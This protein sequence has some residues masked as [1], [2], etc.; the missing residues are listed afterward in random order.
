MRGHK[1]HLSNR[2]PCFIFEAQHQKKQRWQTR[3]RE[4]LEEKLQ[5][6][7]ALT[8]TREEEELEFTRKE[9]Q[10]SSISWRQQLELRRNR[11]FLSLSL[12]HSIHAHEDISS[13]C[14][15]LSSFL[16]WSRISFLK[17]YVSVILSHDILSWSGGRTIAVISWPPSC[18]KCLNPKLE[19]RL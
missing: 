7:H 18:V 3:T 17:L 11:R 10:E 12:F 4:E 1:R 5:Q 8:N 14:C 9:W 16:S 6:T 13:Y 15:F 19:S 2:N